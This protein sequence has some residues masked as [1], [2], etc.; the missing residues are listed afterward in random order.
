MTIHH[1]QQHALDCSICMNYE[2]TEMTGAH[3]HS[4]QYFSIHRGRKN[5]TSFNACAALVKYDACH[6]G[7]FLN[8][9]SAI[10]GSSVCWLCINNNCHLGY[11]TNFS[12]PDNTDSDVRVMVRV[13][14]LSFVARL[15]RKFK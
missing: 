7:Y 3:F 1:T 10:V 5:C 12:G 15:P 13:R 4:L 8:Q 14:G 6:S 11:V 2:K 9:R